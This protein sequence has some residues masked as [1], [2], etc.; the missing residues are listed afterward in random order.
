MLQTLAAR[1]ALDLANKV[2]LVLQ[3]VSAFLNVLMVSNWN[4]VQK[5]AKANVKMIK[6]GIKNLID[7]VSYAYP[8]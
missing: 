5:D 3:L 1:I 7:V 8:D 6:N 2:K 4:L